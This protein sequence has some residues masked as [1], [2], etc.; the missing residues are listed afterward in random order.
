[1]SCFLGA[2]LSVNTFAAHPSE[3]LFLP[4]QT[5]ETSLVQF[6]RD[7]RTPPSSSPPKSLK[8]LCFGPETTDHFTRGLEISGIAPLSVDRTP[9][10]APP[11]TKWIFSVKVDL[12]THFLPGLPLAYMI[13]SSPLF[14]SCTSR[15]WCS[16]A[17]PIL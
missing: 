1:L 15:W 4:S 8:K 17:S 11:F 2:F 12:T 3:V 7:L 6:H 10:T 5:S 14:L 9:P 13:R 16:S